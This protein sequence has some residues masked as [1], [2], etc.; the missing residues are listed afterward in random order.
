MSGQFTGNIGGQ[1]LLSATT[2]LPAAE[3]NATSV[4]VALMDGSAERST[5]CVPPAERLTRVVVPAT[6]S[7]MNTSGQEPG[8]LKTC[9]HVFV[10]PA[11]RFVDEEKNATNRPSGVICGR[12]TTS[13]RT[14]GSGE[15]PSPCVPALFTLTRSV[16]PSTRSRTKMSL[17]SF[18][19]PATRFVAL[20]Q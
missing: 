12:L 6:R 13:P 15:L 14:A 11:T 19:S 4:A 1:T 17:R 18:V 9:G 20:D 8:A 2:R 10:S 7:R 16:V 5:A 3:K